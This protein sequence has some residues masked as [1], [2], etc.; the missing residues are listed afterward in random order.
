L[1][2]LL[3]EAKKWATKCKILTQKSERITSVSLGVS[4]VSKAIINKR[5]GKRPT[6]RQIQRKTQ[7]LFHRYTFARALMVTAG[8][9]KGLPYLGGN[10]GTLAIR[11]PK[12]GAPHVAP[13]HTSTRLLRGAYRVALSL[14]EWPFARTTYMRTTWRQFVWWRIAYSGELRTV[15]NCVRRRIVRWRIALQPSR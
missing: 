14:H 6:K 15:A 5:V 7:S 13:N 1:T 12:R 10:F 11:A 2:I 9:R 8:R 4:P 3:N